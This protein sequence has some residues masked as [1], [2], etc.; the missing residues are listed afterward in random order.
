MIPGK[1]SQFCSHPS[2]SDARSDRLVSLKKRRLDNVQ[3]PEPTERVLTSQTSQKIFSRTT[4]IAGA[5]YAREV[6]L[7]RYV[8][9][10][11]QEP[12]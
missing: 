12:F 6:G 8:P 1:F 10:G 7:M 11:V 4:T 9:I 5:W 3:I 2:R